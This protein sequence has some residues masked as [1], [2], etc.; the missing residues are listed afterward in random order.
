MQ[1]HTAECRL[2]LFQLQSRWAN[3]AL[4][5]QQSGEGSATCLSPGRKVLQIGFVHSRVRMH[6]KVFMF[7][8]LSEPKELNEGL[9]FAGMKTLT[10]GCRGQ[11]C[12]V[13]TQT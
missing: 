9:C 12:V 3:S 5:T 2:I 6:V 13:R 8:I 10:I 1:R 7:Q 11:Q 4:L